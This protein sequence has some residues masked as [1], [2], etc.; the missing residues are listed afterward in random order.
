VVPRSHKA[1]VL[2]SVK[3]V[4][5]FYSGTQVLRTSSVVIPNSTH[6]NADVLKSAWGAI[7][8]IALVVVGYR[9]KSCVAAVT[10]HSIAENKGSDIPVVDTWPQQIGTAHCHDLHHQLNVQALINSG[11][12]AQQVTQRDSRAHF[13]TRLPKTWAELLAY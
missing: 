8:S 10:V 4:S 9:R 1:L 3:M 12:Q 13:Q 2:P 11:T 5:Q 7:G 6:H